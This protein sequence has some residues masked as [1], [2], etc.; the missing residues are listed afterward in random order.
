M[1]VSERREDMPYKAAAL[2]RRLM[3][4]AVAYE[5]PILVQDIERELGIGFIE[6]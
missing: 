2:A 3:D 5:L 4:V 1:V 6:D